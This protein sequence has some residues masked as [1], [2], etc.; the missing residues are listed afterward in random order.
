MDFPDVGFAQ[1]KHTDAGLSDAAA[2]GKGKFFVNDG[3]L[4]GKAGAFRA[5]GFF[6]LGKKGILIHADTHGGQFQGNVQN[7]IIYYDIRI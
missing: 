4:E 6:Q 5:A 7:R 2:N 1:E 3:F